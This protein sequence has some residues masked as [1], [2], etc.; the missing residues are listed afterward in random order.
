MSDK[1]AVS[2]FLVSRCLN[3]EV[4]LFFNIY[5]FN[6]YNFNNKINVHFLIIYVMRYLLIVDLAQSNRGAIKV[7][8]MGCIRE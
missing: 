5:I 7:F 1:G 8:D 4:F 3:T 2:I 6:I